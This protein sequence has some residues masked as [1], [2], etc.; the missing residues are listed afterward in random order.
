MKSSGSLK[1]TILDGLFAL[2]RKLCSGTGP[3][4]SV[5]RVDETEVV[6]VRAQTDN[7]FQG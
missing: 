3:R 6:E 2:V 1:E 7:I 5:S 4:N